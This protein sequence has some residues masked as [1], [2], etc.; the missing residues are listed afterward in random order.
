MK[1]C[2]EE[3]CPRCGKKF[4]RISISY[5]GNWDEKRDTSYECPYCG[6][7]F[8]IHLFPYE[9]IFVQKSK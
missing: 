8:P 5:P 3:I 6:E 9:D 7:S 1:H 4:K 2:E